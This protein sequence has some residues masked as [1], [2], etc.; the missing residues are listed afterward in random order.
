MDPLSEQGCVHTSLS[1]AALLRE[2]SGHGEPMLTVESGLALPLLSASEALFH[3]VPAS[4][5]SFLV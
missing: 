5:V 2:T 3:P 1:A 4:V